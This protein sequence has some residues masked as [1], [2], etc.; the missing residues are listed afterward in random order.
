MKLQTKTHEKNQEM[1]G[2]RIEEAWTVSVE[3]YPTF[4]PLD[5][6]THTP[7]GRILHWLEIKCRDIVWGQYDDIFMSFEKFLPLYLAAITTRIPGV[8]VVRCAG[9]DIRAVNVLE[10]DAQKY[11]ILNVGRKDRN[12]P[13]DSEPIIHVPSDLFV[14]IEDSM[15]L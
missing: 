1:V 15:W 5:A 6:Y 11:E 7:F 3:H 12:N 14:K 4:N 13:L 2:K 10:I 8:F 9:D